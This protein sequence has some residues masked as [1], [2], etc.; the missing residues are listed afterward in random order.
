MKTNKSTLLPPLVKGQLWKTEKGQ[1]EIMEVGK[2][3]AH[4]RL[5]RDEKRFPTSLGRIE[6]VRDYLRE[7]SGKLIKKPQLAKAKA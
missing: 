5:S 1:V 4:Y 7:H 2:L 6:M 3:L